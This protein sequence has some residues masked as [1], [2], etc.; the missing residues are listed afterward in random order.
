[1]ST[2]QNIDTQ[3]KVTIVQHDIV[4][5]DIQ[6]NL[7]HISNLLEKANPIT[8]FI[9]LPEM[10]ATGFTM[11]PERVAQTNEDHPIYDW[12]QKIANKYNATVVGSMAFAVTDES[13][14]ISYYNRLF[15]VYPV[16]EGSF[17]TQVF[18]YDKIELFVHGNEHRV[19]T[20]G[21][22]K[23][24]FSY[25]NVS[26]SS[27][28]CFDLRFPYVSYNIDR[29]KYYYEILFCIANW[30]SKRIAHWEP[31]LRA[32]ALE[33]QAYVIAV[34]RIGTDIN[35]NEHNGKSMVINHFGEVV[36]AAP[37]GESVLTVP[38]DIQGLWDWRMSFPMTPQMQENLE[39]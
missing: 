27:I 25:M 31:L 17:P 26:I 36:A 5:E 2:E 35:G 9:V 8:N 33:N 24:Y 15:Y 22:E 11:K 29:E 10:F 6:A 3:L 18:K 16:E 4:W 14:N 19:Y 37:E 7:N 1:M 20:P 13:D 12:M 34:N 23:T 28:I 21:D 39:N 38:I 30:P 32:R